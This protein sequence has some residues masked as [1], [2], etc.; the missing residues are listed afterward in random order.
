MADPIDYHLFIGPHGQVRF[1]HSYDMGLT[2]SE[3]RPHE[4]WSYGGSMEALFYGN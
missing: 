4:E 3:L 2:W 1:F